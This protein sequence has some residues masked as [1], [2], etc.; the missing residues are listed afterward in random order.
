MSKN[1]A[2]ICFGTSDTF[3]FID[4]FTFKLRYQN[5]AISK[6]FHVNL[7]I[8]VLKLEKSTCE[9]NFIFDYS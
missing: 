8:I 3:L 4:S 2:G 6:W 7:S 5:Y 1:L 9:V